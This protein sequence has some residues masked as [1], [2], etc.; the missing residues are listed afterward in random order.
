MNPKIEQLINNIE[1]VILGK[2]AVI[3]KIVC[4]MLA[5]GHV[6]IEDVPGV[7]KTLLAQTLA[8]SVSGSFRRIQFTPDLMPSD[9]IGYTAIDMSTG[10]SEYREGAAMCNFLLADE[11]NRTS[12]K[13]QSA[14]LEAME[15]KQI[16]VDGVTHQLPVP[17]MTLATQN[18]IETYGTYH[19]PEAQLDR[20]IMRVS[21]G[22]PDR[23]AEM[24]MLNNMPQNAEV[25]AVMSLSEL[26]ELREAAK[27]IAVADNIKAYILSIVNATRSNSQLVK[28]G[29][30]PRASIALYKAAQAMALMN[31]RGFVTPD[32]VKSVAVSVL[33]HRIIL[34]AGQQQFATPAQLI[35][36][37]LD[38]IAVPV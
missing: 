28:L 36:K 13:V 9:V 14:L 27:G 33:A 21:I 10:K 26:V 24:L 7:G 8:K 2:R 30:S 35:G 18:P 1:K 32:D 11:I 17:F 29:A 15:E 3:E 34:A 22:Y 38:D 4:A 16:S 25:S 23:A 5:E 19:L 12:P 20:F 37:I 6:L 31:D